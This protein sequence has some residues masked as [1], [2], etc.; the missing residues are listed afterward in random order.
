MAVNLTI[1]TSW[2][3]SWHGEVI[4]NDCD[5]LA[6]KFVKFPKFDPIGVCRVCYGKYYEHQILRKEVK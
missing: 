3:R 4:C 2:I 6:F 1:T 5:S